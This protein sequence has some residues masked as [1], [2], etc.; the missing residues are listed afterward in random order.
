MAVERPDRSHGF[1][2]KVA[3]NAM[4][5]V[6]NNSFC[7][8]RAHPGRWLREDACILHVGKEVSEKKVAD[9][10]MRVAPLSP[11]IGYDKASE[12]AHTAQRESSTFR[13]NAVKSGYIDERRFYKVVDLSRASLRCSV[14]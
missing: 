3:L 9:L 7:I 6:S 12:I 4:R 10:P 11:V 13:G 8:R 2:G 5:P 1:Q 14:A